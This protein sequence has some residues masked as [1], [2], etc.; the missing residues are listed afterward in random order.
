[1]SLE[2]YAKS[3]HAENNWMVQFLSGKMEGE[4]Q[5]ED[6]AVMKEV[7][8]TR[9]IVGL[10]EYKHA[11]MARFDQYF[12]W[13]Y[14][15]HPSDQPK[16]HTR[17]LDG[18]PNTNEKSN[19]MLKEDSQAWSLLLWQNKLD[20]KLHQ[21]SQHLFGLQGQELFSN[22]DGAKAKAPGAS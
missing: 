9:F 11:S 6:L 7:L 19:L 16:C 4:V 17:F 8:R 21:Y 10:L 12:N 2:E 3:P 13:K 18:D 5:T 20:M 15:P 22:L 14:D 1:M